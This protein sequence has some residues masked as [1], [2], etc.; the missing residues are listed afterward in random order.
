M[1]DGTQPEQWFTVSVGDEY[2]TY[3]C[4]GKLLEPTPEVMA[5]AHF[6]ACDTGRIYVPMFESVGRG[7]HYERRIRFCPI[8]WL[9]TIREKE[10]LSLI[11]VKRLHMI[12][13]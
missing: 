13:V 12:T 2:A 7:Q 5:K 6:V 4:D 10:V 9:G 3:D 11:T 8:D 1:V